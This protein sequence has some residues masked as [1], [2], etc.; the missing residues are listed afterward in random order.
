MVDNRQIFRQ[1]SLERLS[2]PEQLDLLMQ[3][4]SPKGWVALLASCG[5]VI[6]VISW[7]IFGS[8]PT[9]VNGTCILIRPSGVSEIV[10]P[11]AGRVADIS[12]N[13]GDTIRQGQ[14]IAR[15]EKND[16]LDQIRRIQAKLHELQAQEEQLK[17]I[18]LLSEQQQSAYLLKSEKNLGTSIRTGEERLGILEARIQAEAKLLEQG[19]ITRQA[20]LVTKLEHANL[21]QEIN[22]NRNEILKIELS[23][24]ESRKHI[25]NE[26]NSIAIQ[27]NETSRNLAGQIRETDESSLVY[28][29]YSGRVLEIRL[30]EN[31]LI[32]AGTPILSVEQTGNSVNDLEALIYTAPL[33]GKKVKTNMDVQISPSTARREEF[34]VMLGMVRMVADFP[35]TKQGMMRILKN[36]QLVQHLTS[37]T[38]SVA[39]Q[40]DLIPSDSTVSGYRWSSPKG[41]AYRIESGTLCSATIRVMNQSP[42]SLVIPFLRELLGI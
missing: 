38:A 12:V 22:N 29:P 24:I 28:S 42:I 23:R 36:D 11:G 18:N 16:A 34:G 19:L 40:A 41:P 7:E 10:A 3:V 32:N 6:L 5:L 26:L 9:H 35:S 1:V 30:S 15:L 21:K 17:S 25:Q 20:W 14:L 13:V 2:S 27:I 8:I 31:M 39:V 4:A 37:G 33:D